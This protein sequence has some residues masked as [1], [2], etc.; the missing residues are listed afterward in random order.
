MIRISYKNKEELMKKRRSLWMGILAATILAAIILSTSGCTKSSTSPNVLTSPASSSTSVPQATKTLKIGV[1]FDLGSD[2]GIDSVNAIQLMA[3]TDN[4]RGGVPVGN[5]KYNIQVIQ[6]SN[7]GTQVK[8][9][10]SI[11]RLVFEDKVNY[12]LANGLFDGGWLDITEANKV[13]A[14]S[15]DPNAMVSLSPKLKYAFGPSFQNP[16]I[17][18]I[19]GWFCKNYPEVAGNMVCAYPDNQFGHL[20]GMLT[21][22]YFKVFTGKQPE[23]EYYPAS[24]QDL[25]SLGTKVAN[26]K[27]SGFM[28]MSG[29]AMT[30]GIVFNAVYQAGFRGQLFTAT[31]ESLQTWQ[32]AVTPAALDGFICGAYPFEFDSLSNS[33][34]DFKNL[35]IAKYGKWESPRIASCP[36]YPCLTAALGQAGSTDTDKVAAVI[37][38]GLKFNTPIG[39]GI[40]ISRPDLGNERTVDSICEYYIKQIKGGQVK[41]LGTI[42]IDEGLKYFQQINAAPPPMMSPPGGPSGGPPGATPPGGMPPGGPPPGNP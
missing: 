18:S 22:N 6:Y 17:S 31:E 28:C 20:V 11:N 35:W 29:T 40:M 34:E 36:L 30:D 1:V 25:S 13:I 3:D 4:A 33:S 41:L 16:S 26:L 42:S 12:I 15:M 7:E 37:S 39:S 21:S 5:D 32:Q 8:E 23:V 14:F 10:S 9:V 27:P 2:I 19:I 38:N 24:S